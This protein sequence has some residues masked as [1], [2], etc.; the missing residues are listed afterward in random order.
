LRPTRAEIHIDHFSHNLEFVRRQIGERPK[1]MAIVKANA[2]GHGL[3]IIARA[4]LK[5]EDVDA[6]GVATEEE[7]CKLR[8][9]TRKPILVL[10]GALW[11]EIDIFLSHQLDFT[12]TDLP[13]LEKIAE[14]A[15]ALGTRARVHLKVDTGMRRIGVEPQDAIEVMRE[16]ERYSNEIEFAGLSTHFATSDELDQTFLKRQIDTFTQVIR[17][18]KQAGI[19]LPTIHAANSGAVL[20]CP[21]ETAFD[22]VRPGIMLYGYTPSLELDERYGTNLQP[23]LELTSSI[24]Y[25]KRVATG[26]GVS[27]NLRWHAQQPTTICTVPIGYGDGYPRLLTNRAFTIIRGKRYPVVGTI[28]MDQILVDVGDDDIQ[29][30]ERATFL[31]AASTAQGSPAINAWTL[32]KDIGTIPY[33]ILTNI[34]ARVPRVA[35]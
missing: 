3:E 20:Q 33:E 28:C 21:R 2:Y 27:Y 1:I 14:R 9:I 30:G 4:A 23:P 13:T 12:L 7:G 18:A 6:F 8:N 24:V 10:T 32:A 29:V 11:H 17:E 22:M 26:E 16:I 15:R 34:A 31:E 19:T 35:V 25:K 5:S